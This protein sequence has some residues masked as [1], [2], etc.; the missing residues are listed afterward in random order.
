M[1]GT[2]RWSLQKKGCL[3]TPGG[4]DLARGAYKLGPEEGGTYGGKGKGEA[5]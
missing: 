1:K 2:H 3:G 4:C 5:N